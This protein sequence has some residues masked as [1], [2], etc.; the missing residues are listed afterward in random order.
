MANSIFVWPGQFSSSGGTVTFSGPI[1]AVDGTLAAP[2][3]AFANETNT[4]YRRS[5][6]S[7]LTYEIS[8]ID[9][10]RFTTNAIVLKDVFQ[11][12][13]SST[14]DPV[15][16]A[17]LIIVRDSAAGIFAIKNA[18]NATSLR[19]YGTTTGPKYL[20]MSHDGTNGVLDTAASSGLIS[21]AP[22][23]ATSVAI[24]KTTTFPTTVAS[25]TA[26]GATG[27]AGAALSTGVPQM[28]FSTGASGAGID[29][30][31]GATG[32]VGAVYHFYN[33]G[34]GLLNIYAVGGTINGATGTTAY[35]ITTT[36]NKWAVAT[37]F[38]AG[39]WRIR[40]NT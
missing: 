25:V 8:G 9:Q 35:A 15:S 11:L 34:S 1:L 6:A 20:S 37:S 14:S 17:D 38:A 33:E 4:G 21:I 2:A 18:T 22:T 29:L 12:A 10:Y 23:N 36:G 40:G 26:T 32:A 30:P 31:G 28:V 24:G 27:G 7:T 39:A 3:Y 5:A 16:A 19:V 13:W